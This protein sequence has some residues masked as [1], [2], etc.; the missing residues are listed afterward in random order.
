MKLG[1]AIDRIMRTL[2]PKI[3]DAL[4]N[5]VFAAVRDEEISTI[6][7]AVYKAYEPKRYRRRGGNGGL[8]DP[9]NIEIVGERASNRRL[10]VINQT[11]PNPGGCPS[12]GVTTGKDLPTLIERGDGY[13]GNFYDFPHPGL[14]YMGPRPF[15]KKTIEHLR[16]NRAH[17]KAMRDGLKRRG[18]DVK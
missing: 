12:P 5:E 13:R 1:D 16:S 11:E 9:Y 8:L 15:T 2:E 7:Q 4:T 14:A 6:D 3:N 10:E 18:V 17:V